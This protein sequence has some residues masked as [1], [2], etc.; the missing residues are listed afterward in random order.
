MPLETI[1]VLT[2]VVGMFGVFAAVLTYAEHQSRCAR[3]LRDAQSS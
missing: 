2:V 3:R 1:V